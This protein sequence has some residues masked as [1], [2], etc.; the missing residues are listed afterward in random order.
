MTFSFLTWRSE[1]APA[2]ALTLTSLLF[3]DDLKASGGTANFFTR[4]TL[5]LCVR[6]LKAVMPWLAASTH[7]LFKST[8]VTLAH[9]VTTTKKKHADKRIRTLGTVGTAAVGAELVSSPLPPR[10]T[11]PLSEASV[12]RD[13]IFDVALEAMRPTRASTFSNARLRAASD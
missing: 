11:G 10:F 12:C 4:F 13:A 9:I 5:T 3:G 2:T 6:S 8:N 7:S 1:S